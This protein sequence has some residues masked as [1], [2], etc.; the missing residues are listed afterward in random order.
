MIVFANHKRGSRC[1]K[2][3]GNSELP[4]K[5]NTERLYK[6]QNCFRLLGREL[7]SHLNITI[8]SLCRYLW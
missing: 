1:Y 3:P 2:V 4:S 6:L 7:E 8:V 5:G